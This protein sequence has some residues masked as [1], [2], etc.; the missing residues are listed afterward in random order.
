MSTQLLRVTSGIAAE[1]MKAHK[2]HTTVS[3]NVLRSQ[4]S[5]KFSYG[6]VP[7]LVDIISA[8]PDDYKKP[9][10]AVMCKPHRCPHIAMTGCICVYCPVGP[11]SDFDY[12]TQ[13]YTGYETTSMKARVYD[14]CEQTRGRVEQ[15]K[16]LGSSVEVSICLPNFSQML[17]Y[18]CTRLE[19]GDVACDLIASFHLAKDAGFKV[20]AHMVSNLP[21]VGVERDMEQFKEYFENPAF[22]SDAVVTISGNLRELALNRMKELGAECRDVRFRKAGSHEIHHKVRPESE[23]PLRRDC[24]AN[25][26]SET[27]LFYEDP[28]KDILVGLLRSRKCSEEGTLRPELVRKEGDEEVVRELHVYS[29]AVP[30]Y[31]RNSTRFQYQGFG[32]LLMQEAERIAREEHGS[33]KLAVISG[34]GTLDYYRKLGYELDGPDMSKSLLRGFDA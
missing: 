34:V 18:G 21:N 6:G 20:V 28:V 1:L 26:G 25:G 8:N 7:R 31:G 23:E 16:S 13:S 3:L 4:I 19:I 15:L 29:T 9:S 32:T 30:V 14:P 12:S 24:T 2:S 5:K 27:F 10:V 17:R 11:D 33:I 22:R